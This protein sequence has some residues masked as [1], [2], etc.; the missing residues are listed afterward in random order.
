MKREEKYPNTI[1]FTFKN[2]NP[3]NKFG[4][5]CVVR[6]IAEATGQSWET[7][8]REMTELGIKKG[9]VLNDASLYP[10]YLKEKG[11]SEIKEPRKHDNTKMS[12][13]EWLGSRDGWL[14]HSYKVVAN[15]GSHHVVAIMNNK[16]IDTWDSTN[17]T[18]HKFWVKI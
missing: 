5:D 9:L 13:K 17:Q 8:I 1:Y 18:M 7:T 12:V 4:S 3:K 11:F 14:W 10:L 16:V 15:V 6:A 2:V